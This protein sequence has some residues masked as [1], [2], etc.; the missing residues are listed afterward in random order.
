MKIKC[1][2]IQSAGSWNRFW[3]NKSSE[4]EHSTDTCHKCREFESRKMNIFFY[5]H[6]YFDYHEIICNFRQSYSFE[7]IWTENQNTWTS[8]I[9][10]WKLF[11]LKKKAIE[12]VHVCDVDYGDKR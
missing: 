5:V 10:W 12:A 1:L 4:N 8:F 9:G 3:L 2:F 6:S 11:Y 7:I